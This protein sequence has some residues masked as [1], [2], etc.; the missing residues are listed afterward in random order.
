M[1]SVNLSQRSDA[2]RIFE[3]RLPVS[4]MLAPETIVEVMQS[5][6]TRNE[7]S[8]QLIKITS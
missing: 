3:R 7:P 6:D 2:W 1:T 5:V 8:L 4:Q